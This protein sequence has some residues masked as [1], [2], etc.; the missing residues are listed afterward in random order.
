MTALGQA[1]KLLVLD[2]L[3]PDAREEFKR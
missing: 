3:E 2:E 1:G